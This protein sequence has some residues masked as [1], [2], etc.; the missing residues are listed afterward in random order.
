MMFTCQE[1]FSTVCTVYDIGSNDKLNLE[2]LSAACV[3]L[4]E[5]LEPEEAESGVCMGNL[6]QNVI[7]E[8]LNAYGCVVDAIGQWRAYSDAN[9]MWY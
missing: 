1:S 6:R 7:T 9:S 8:T 2:Y 4:V 5:S 3:S